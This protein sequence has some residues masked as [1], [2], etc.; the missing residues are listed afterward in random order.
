MENYLPKS[1]LSFFRLGIL[2]FGLLGSSSLLGAECSLLTPPILEVV[3][4]EAAVV[5]LNV[6]NSGQKD[7]LVV[8]DAQVPACC[9]LLVP[10]DRLIPLNPES[11]HMILLPINVR[12]STPPGIQVLTLTVDD[13]TFPVTLNIKGQQELTFSADQ[14]PAIAADGQQF[15]ICLKGCNLGNTPALIALEVIVDNDGYGVIEDET[16]ELLPGETACFQ[17]HVT[18]LPTTCRARNRVVQIIASDAMTG[19]QLFAHCSVVDVLPCGLDEMPDP[20][21]RMPGFSRTFVAGQEGKLIGGVEFYGKGF[22][23][24]AG[25][26]EVTYEI[27]VPSDSRT[28]LYNEYQRLFVGVIDPDFEFVLGD[29]NYYLTPLTERW[30]YGRGIGLDFNLGHVTYG[31]FYRQNR[32]NHSL[33]FEEGA[34]Y[35]NYAYNPY[36][37]ISLNFIRRSQADTPQGN[38]I[39]VRHEEA[40]APGRFIGLEIAYD[41]T[42][43]HHH[44]DRK[45]FDIDFK[46]TFGRDSS[47]YFTRTYAGKGFYGYYNNSDYYS[48]GVDW[49]ISPTTRFLLST[50]RV[51]QNLS[52]CDTTAPRWRDYTAKLSYW[53]DACS[54]ITLIGQFLMG[55]DAFNPYNYDFSQVWGGIQ[56]SFTSANYALY[57]ISEVGGQKDHVKDVICKPLQRYNFDFNVNLDPNRFFTLHYEC[58]NTDAYDARQWRYAAG[59]AFIWRYQPASFAEIFTRVINDRFYGDKQVDGRCFNGRYIHGMGRISHTF[60]NLHHI[61][62]RTDLFLSRHKDNRDEYKFLLAYTIPT[63]TPVKWRTDIGLVEGMLYDQITAEPIPNAVVAIGDECRLTDEYGRYRFSNLSPGEYTLSAKLLPEKM[64]ESNRCGVP[65]DI[66]GGK[67]CCKDVAATYTGQLEGCIRIFD[68]EE[69]TIASSRS[70]PFPGVDGVFL[71]LVEKKGLASA[72]LVLSRNGTGEIISTTSNYL[73][74]FRFDHLHP[75]LWTLKIIPSQIPEGHYVEHELLEVFVQRQSVDKIEIKVLPTPKEIKPLL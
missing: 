36:S 33:D 64:L 4:G 42:S 46:S 9:E 67:I 10:I 54:Q 2:C 34:A 27:L 29:T 43:K 1:Y 40:P 17:G 48:A 69:G 25:L 62:F 51:C 37:H 73:G 20:W 13:K 32:L 14:M 35:I 74:N 11:S 55:K 70:Q 71:S 60:S 58:G 53:Y 59:G 44:G 12:K 61:G 63:E 72:R 7:A 23:D 52:H 26:R 16:Y 66:V 38:I 30:G 65:F 39:S 47:F 19:E 75:G 3:P 68:Y 50:N 24:E 41:T 31:S 5:I 56:Y 22:V 28:N 18:I 45:G 15:P 8:F 57:C 21:I 49:G 6:D